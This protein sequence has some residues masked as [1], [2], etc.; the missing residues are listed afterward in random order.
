METLNVIRLLNK[1][2]LQSMVDMLT[3]EQKRIDDV[4]RLIVE[5]DNAFKTYFNLTENEYDELLDSVD[6][7]GHEEKQRGILPKALFYIDGRLKSIRSL[8]DGS[9]DQVIALSKLRI[10]IKHLLSNM[11]ARS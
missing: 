7:K 1:T 4:M 2:Y 8:R 5:S 6:V 3:E 10:V 11:N 9:T